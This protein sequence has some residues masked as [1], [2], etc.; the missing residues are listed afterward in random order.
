VPVS[1]GYEGFSHAANANGAALRHLRDPGVG[2]RRKGD[3]R[4]RPSGRGG[5]KAPD[6]RQWN[7]SAI[8]P[9]RNPLPR[10]P[11]IDLIGEILNEIR[12]CRTPRT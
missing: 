1:S 10:P 3:A 2:E 12:L 11:W 9:K 6:G 7:S 8:E 4:S 5:L